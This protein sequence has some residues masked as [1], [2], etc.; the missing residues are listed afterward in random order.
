MSKLVIVESPSKAKTIKKYLGKDYEVIASQGHIIDLPVSKLG[1]DIEN[2][3]KPEYKTMKG[4]SNI[5]KEIKSSA[6]GKDMIYLATDPDREG[7]AIAWHLKNVL[8]IPDNQKCRIEFNE[9]TKNAVKK[10]VDTPR[11]VDKNLVDAQQAR[12]ILDRIVGYKLSPLLWRKVKKGTSAGRVQSVALK[13]IV[14][15]EREIQDFKPEDY[16]LMFAKLQRDEDIVT[17]KFY[18]DIQ[19]RIEL[20]DKK[21]VDS[22]IKKIDNKK[23]EIIDIKKSERKKNP[24]APFTT[25][26]LQQE[27]SRK[28]GFGVKKTMM[29]AQKLY[30]S[31][32][33]TYMRTD[34]TRLS[35]DAIKMAKSYIIDEF[36][37]NYYLEREFKA[38]DNAQDAHE[39]IRPSHLDA[40]VEV[41]DKDQLKLYNLILNRFLASQMSVAIYDTTKIRIRVEDYIFHINGSTIKFD[42]FMK[43]YIEGKDDKVKS[44]S[45]DEDDEDEL[46]VLPEFEVGEVLKQKELKADKK[47]TEPPARYTEASLVKVMEE[48]GV[49]RPSTYAPTISTIEDRFYIEKEGRYL[50]PTELGM[51]VN[52]LL[53]D[54][55]KNIVDVKFTADM[56][57]KLDE[58]AEAK[59][60]YVQMLSDFYEPFNKNLEEVQD[61]I[62]K[63]KLTEVE[64]DVVCEKC[65]RK[66]VIKQGRFGKFL[67]CPGYP[68]CSNIKPYNESIDAPCPECGGKVIVKYTKTRRPFYVCENNKN[69]E[70]SFCHYISWTKPKQ[71]K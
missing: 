40:D 25:S 16:Y 47:T 32:Y 56:E 65:G 55:F 30:E 12:R 57:T 21:Q 68:E 70:D 34:S 13:I 27:A 50:K 45:E 54:Y 3:F 62:E 11:V 10:A 26:S 53:E 7:E 43:L 46:K 66:M 61:K 64:S 35:E 14:D 17:A 22:I 6:K 36:G 29:V 24:P 28:L 44:K 19:G 1:V 31:G 9:I 4:K 58:V 48:K 20:K 37:K 69:T 39:A 52:K 67:A 63:V 71:N 49:G 60:N 38:K 5:V 41:L 18:G 42:G 23:Y 8:D 51:A 33:I 59:Q 2:D 15:K